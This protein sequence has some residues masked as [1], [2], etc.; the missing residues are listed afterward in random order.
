MT[1]CNSSVHQNTSNLYEHPWYSQLNLLDGTTICESQSQQKPKSEKPGRKYTNCVHCGHLTADVCWDKRKQLWR[2]FKSC[3]A[4][5]NFTNRHG[6]KLTFEDRAML[7]AK[8]FCQICGT[9]KRLHIDHCH[10]TNK[11]RG[12]LCAAHN[13]GIGLFNEN[14]EDL[15]AAINYLKLHG[16]QI[17]N[18]T[19]TS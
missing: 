15:K 8:P 3:S 2:H 6:F 10:T 9:T 13:Q 7:N 16:N 11:I 14:I 12:Y 19:G 17:Q 1:N 5:I 4:C 18:S